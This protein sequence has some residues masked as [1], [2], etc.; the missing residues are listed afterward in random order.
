[1]TG[2]AERR[3][4]SRDGLSLYARDYAPA[5]DGDRLPVICL[6]GLTRNSADFEDLA[7]WLAS[8]GRRVIVPDT[9]GRG[10][11]D[12]DPQP[13]RYLPR[14]YGRDVVEMMDALAVRRAIFLGTSMGG[15]IMMVVAATS[16]RRMAAAILND[17][18]PEIA[19]EGL[20]RIS[21]YAGKPVTIGDWADARAYVK[22][23]NAVAFPD[24]ED[25]DWD[26][27]ARRSFREDES[28][29]PVL[30]YDPHIADPIR[31]GKGKAPNWLAWFLFRRLARGRPALLVR[32][33]T[34]DIL[35]RDIARRMQARVP[36][37]QFA[38]V[39]GVG[40]APGLDEPEAR[41]AIERFLAP[42]P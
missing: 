17:V 1:M 39:P 19:P 9:R 27:L 3:W 36:A 20:A 38:E 23:N 13:M 31:A 26:R 7:P 37:M 24:F 10:R 28:G 40:H 14:T 16:G 29:K 4:K 35:S 18:G 2:Y 22:R 8:L 30:D 5:G 32:G 25:P 6:H 42:L 15:L 21:A 12:Y 34:S 33:E 11:S 41:S